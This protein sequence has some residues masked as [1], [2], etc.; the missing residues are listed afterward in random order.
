MYACHNLRFLR[1]YKNA[2]NYY[3]QYDKGFSDGDYEETVLYRLAVIYKDTDKSQAKKYAQSLV[4]KYPNSIYNNSII[5][6]LIND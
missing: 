6:N 1:R 3:I 4:D 2:I 5:S